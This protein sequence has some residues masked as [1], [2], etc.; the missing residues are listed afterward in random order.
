MSTA[1]DIAALKA[2][3]TALEKRATAI[4]TRQTNQAARMDKIEAAAVALAAKVGALEG[5]RPPLP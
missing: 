5:A 3:C 2:R 1:T 4:E